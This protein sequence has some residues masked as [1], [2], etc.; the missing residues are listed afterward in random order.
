MRLGKRRVLA[1]LILIATWLAAGPLVAAQPG[2]AYTLTPK[3][4]ER[5]RGSAGADTHAIMRRA[6]KRLDR[7]FRSVV[8]TYRGKT[9]PD[10]ARFMALMEGPAERSEIVDGRFLF[11]AGNS[12]KTSEAAAFILDLVS[13]Q[14]AMATLTH[15]R[16]RYQTLHIRQMEC[17]DEELKSAATHRFRDWA[18]AIRQRSGEVDRFPL[19]RTETP[20]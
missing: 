2:D 12:L 19:S 13:G 7:V 11:V 8:G 17:A 9:H 16:F 10:H 5:L 4:T 6:G 18:D 3:E 15:E 1:G 20:C 14:L